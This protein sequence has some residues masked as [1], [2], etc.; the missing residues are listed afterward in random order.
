MIET[1]I[2][3]LDALCNHRQRVDCFQNASSMH[4]ESGGQQARSFP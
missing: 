4:P 2:P 3:F 1:I